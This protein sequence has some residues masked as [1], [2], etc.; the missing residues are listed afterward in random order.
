MSRLEI[1][2]PILRFL[3]EVDKPKRHVAF[4]EKFMWTV[5][6][7]ILY[8]ALLQI[9]VYGVSAHA[10]DVPERWFNPVVAPSKVRHFT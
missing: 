9:N 10:L 7:L 1:L 5:G 4:R 3:P 2:D 8:F 6:V